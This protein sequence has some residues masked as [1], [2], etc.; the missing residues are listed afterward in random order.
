MPLLGC[1]HVWTCV[2]GMARPWER[3]LSVLSPMILMLRLASF[4][5]EAESSKESNKR[6][7]RYSLLEKQLHVKCMPPSG[8]AGD[9]S[10]SLS[11][12]HGPIQDFQDLQVNSSCSA[13]YRACTVEACV[14]AHRKNRS[15]MRPGKESSSMA[16]KKCFKHATS[17]VRRSG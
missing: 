13:A 1:G 9:A 11:L 6:N 2:D 14:E 17:E 16:S 15:S 12:G 5:P 4:L 8:L 3:A 7:M 10:D